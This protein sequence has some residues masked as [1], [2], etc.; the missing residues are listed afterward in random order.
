MEKVSSIAIPSLVIHGEQD[1]LAPVEQA[2]QMHHCFQSADKR[3][4][5]IPGAGHNDLLYRGLDEYMTAI[6]EF[7][8]A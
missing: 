4:L 6:K 7:T 1:T 5:T 3:L 2:V 8:G